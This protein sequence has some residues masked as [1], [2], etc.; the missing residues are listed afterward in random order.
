VS[1]IL[2]HVETRVTAMYDRHSYDAEK[3]AA[4]DFWGR[5]VEAIL[6]WRLFRRCS[7]WAAVARR[8]R[9]AAFE[10]P[11]VGALRADSTRSSRTML[12]NAS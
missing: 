6:P 4:L 7:G 3:R 10:V 1:K 2:N 8:H 12:L 11:A 9:I 5:R